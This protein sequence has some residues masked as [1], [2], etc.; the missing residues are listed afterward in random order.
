MY[1]AVDIAQSGTRKEERLLGP[2]V[3]RRV[4]LLRR[5]LV[6]MD[7]VP[8][9]EM[10]VQKLSGFDSNAAFLDRIAGATK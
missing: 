2:E 1:P 9:M 4:T 5:T 8:G 10:L 6:Q 7:P 3:L